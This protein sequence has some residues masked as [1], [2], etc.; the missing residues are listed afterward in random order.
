M[1][2]FNP[3]LMEK[4]ASEEQAE[5]EQRELKEA[6]GIVAEDVSVR[7]KGLKDYAFSAIRGL[8]YLL[9]VVLVFLGIVTWINPVSRGMILELLGMGG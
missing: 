2:R 6:Y 5:R 1:T 9:Y 4:I 7:K 8:G 3:V